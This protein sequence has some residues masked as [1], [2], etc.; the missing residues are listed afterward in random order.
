MANNWDKYWQTQKGLSKQQIDDEEGKDT[1]PTNPWLYEAEKQLIS[2]DKIQLLDHKASKKVWIGAKDGGKSRS[3]IVRKFTK[4][5]TDKDAYS[6]D[7]KKYK[8][9]GISRLHN[10]LVNISIEARILGY[11]VPEYVSGMNISYRDV[12]KFDKKKNQTVEYSSFD[13]TNGLAGIEAP[14]LGYFA[15]VH[16]E[17]PVLINDQGKTPTRSEWDASMKTIS[18]S[19]NRSNRRYAMLHKKPPITPEYHFTMNPW[20]GDHPLVEDANMY[21]PEE[22][23]KEF[24]MENLIENHTMSA[25]VSLNDTLYI[26]MTKFANPV[27]RLIERFLLQNDIKSLADW[28]DVSKADYEKITGGIEEFA[29]L[30]VSYELITDHLKDGFSIHKQ[31]LDAIENDNSLELARLL[32]LTYQGETTNKKV[33]NLDNLIT[34]D[35]QHILSTLPN[36]TKIVSHTIAYDV[37]TREGRGFVM[38]PVYKLEKNTILGEKSRS[39]LVGEQ[40]KIAGFGDSA[41]KHSLYSDQLNKLSKEILEKSK[42]YAKNYKFPKF[43]YLDE[44]RINYLMQLK[45]CGYAIG[46]AV[47]HG[48]WDIL[49]RQD[50][51][52]LGIDQGLLIIDK[53]NIK[54]INDLKKVVAK[55]DSDK[56]DESG[57]R[58]KDMDHIN[59]LEYALFPYRMEV[60][61]QIPTIIFEK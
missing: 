43:L 12:N 52:Q 36:D 17:E 50:Y 13:D 31:C 33:Y 18:D 47:K 1:Q 51:L 4:M 38:T 49:H 32:G 22:D 39:I 61:S 41:A 29:A 53:K 27:I 6:L 46:K 24:F 25:Y 28:N 58:E 34:A 5:E 10:A 56:R 21:F 55:E 15:T 2:E 16:V 14:N 3:V 44:N 23:F 20:D 54:L 40:M 37:D 60:F 9:G 35:T 8:Q 45:D 19:V 26:R 7:L 59:S 11:D 30:G 48:S 42:N 57:V